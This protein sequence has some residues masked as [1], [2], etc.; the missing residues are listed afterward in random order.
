MTD[1]RLRAAMALLAMT[2]ALAPGSIAPAQDGRPSV[3]LYG[4]TGLIDLPSAEMQPDG[5]MSASYAQFGNT[6]RRNFTF[7]IL[8][9]LSGTLRYATINN[10]GKPGDPDY[11]LF[12]RSFDVS[13]QFLKEKGWQPAVTLGFRDILGTGIYSA[14]YL[15][16]TKTLAQDFKLS[17]GIGWGRL[18]S[19]GGVSNP[20]CSMADTFCERQT[21]FG[22]GGKIAFDNFFSGEKMGFFGGVEWSTPVDGLTLKA[23][24]SSDA[25]IPEEA[26]FDNKLPVN[27]GAEYRLR[28]GIT[29]GGYYMY[30][31]AVGFNV[32]LSGN[33][34]RPPVPQ[35]LGT[36]PVPVNPR[37]EGAPRGGAWVADAGI[38]DQL[39]EAV[40]AA[41]SDDGITLEEMRFSSSADAV[42]VFII[43]RQINQ[44]PKAIGRTARVLAVAM[45]FSVETFR[46]TPVES[47]MPTTTVTVDRS[48]LENQVDRPNAGLASWETSTFAGA[49]PA[50]HGTYLWKR[51]VYPIVDWSIIP[52][53]TLQLFGGNEGFRPQ[54]T[55]EARGSLRF[56]RGISV[57]GRIRQPVL[58]VFDDPGPQ[59]GDRALPPVRRDSARYYAGWDP[60]LM[61][62]TGD[63]LF[64]LNRDTYA[65][66]SAGFLERQ[67]AG[68]SGEVLWKPVEQSWG[69]G[70]ELNWVAQRDFDKF[71]GFDYYDYQ[72]VTGH[73]SLYWDTGWNGIETQLSAGRYLAGDWG[74][75]LYVS[76]QFANGWSVGAFVTKTDVTAEEFGE[77]SFDKGIT[78]SIPLRWA[79]PFETRQTIDGQLRSL[80]SDAGAF[81]NIANRLYPT[82]RHLDRAGLEQN[83]GAF[84]E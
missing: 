74:G 81:L 5:Q 13:F 70:A 42:D 32:V 4:G 33:P 39:A 43:D 1:R 15:V 2:S 47:G 72:V 49:L 34:W 54:L 64:K 27:F 73:A 77:G 44:M 60:K 14:E 38:R 22:E 76:R 52:V 79:T 61:R 40:S 68:V 45:P 59:E 18:A 3:N 66:A 21:D 17:A 35:N 78:L 65:R 29:L 69:L 26:D 71:I 10:Y 31:D 50:L 28:D 36:G 19:V 20:F 11:D 63:Y 84:W 57:S 6:I 56:S 24:V 16:A 37:P 12:D 62:L 67:Y 58:G 8:P 48:D 80:S 55:I 46:I 23:E 25:Y 75:T 41:L 9:R 51:D 53:P 82:V 7:Q 83:W 30:G